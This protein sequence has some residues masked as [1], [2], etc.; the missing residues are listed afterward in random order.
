MEQ[1]RERITRGRERRAGSWLV[2]GATACGLIALG[3]LGS[4]VLL[5]STE[6][7]RPPPANPAAVP[8]AAPD[9]EVEVLLTPEAVA[10]AG[11][12]AVEVGMVEPRAVTEVPGVVMANAYREVK[13]SPLVG[14]V[15]RKVHAELG[16]AVKEGTPL[17]TLF[18][19]ELADAQTKYLSMRAML[20]ADHQRRE[21]TRELVD[22]GAASRQ[23]LEEA[24][25]VHASHATEVEAARQRLLLLG[26]SKKQLDSL[27]YPRQVMADVVVPA[28]IA[29]VITSRSANF[30]QVVGMGE[31]LFV[32]TDLSEVW[33]GG[34]STSKTFH[35]CVWALRRHSRRRPTPS[36]GF[37]AA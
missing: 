17:V 8:T 22:I 27:K 1:G 31:V 15:V 7:F 32:V 25:A 33:V 11:I 14:G 23:E 16:T 34:V 21:R 28:P 24:T 10:Q 9:A 18:S 2:R 37:R 13:V 26:M 35:A 36:S 29:G 19:T 3:A 30:G 6:T 5:R 12:K 20:E 4:L